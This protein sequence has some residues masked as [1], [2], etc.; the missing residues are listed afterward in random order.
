ML[1]TRKCRTKSRNC[2][3]MHQD[4]NKYIFVATTVYSHKSLKEFYTNFAANYWLK[5]HSYPIVLL[6][7]SCPALAEPHVGVVLVG[8]EA[9]LV[10]AA[11]VQLV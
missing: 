6:H 5:R 4:I 8:L 9:H 3:I 1:E 11:H 10:G 2:H 7:E